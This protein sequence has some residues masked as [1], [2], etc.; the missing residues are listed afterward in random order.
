MNDHA[1]T[2]FLNTPTP[3]NSRKKDGKVP[4]TRKRRREAEAELEAVNDSSGLGSQAS[5]HVGKRAK[6]SSKKTLKRTPA[7]RGKVQIQQRDGGFNEEGKQTG[8]TKPPVKCCK[9]NIS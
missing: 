8:P 7:G 9:S 6:R 5:I 4:V 1:T 3:A 2:M